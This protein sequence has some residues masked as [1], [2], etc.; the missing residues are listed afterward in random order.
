M[1]FAYSVVFSS[2]SVLKYYAGLTNYYDLGVINESF[3]VATYGG[4]FW[5]VNSVYFAGHFSPILYLF[6]PIYDA[7]PGPPVLLVIQ[8]FVIGFGVLPVYM[9][10][11]GATRDRTVSTMISAVY[12]MYP[13]LQG[14]NAFAFHAASLYP[15]LFGLALL[16]W[17]RRGWSQYYVCLAAI[18]ASHEIAPL[19]IGSLGLANL[20]R[21]CLRLRPSI[22][23]EVIL[24]SILTIAFGVLI[25]LF[26]SA[27]TRIAQSGTTAFYLTGQLRSVS[28]PVA[29]GSWLMTIPGYFLAHPA[30]TVASLFVDFPNKFLYLLEMLGPVMFL[31]VLDLLAL[32]PFWVWIMLIYLTEFRYYYW[33][34]A[35]YSG[36]VVAF[37]FSSLAAVFSKLAMH[38]HATRKLALGMVLITVMMSSYLSPLNPLTGSSGDPLRSNWWFVI[39]PHEEDVSRIIALVPPAASVATELDLAVFVSGRLDL[40]VPRGVNLA[41]A[42]LV[43]LTRLPRKPPDFILADLNSPWFLNSAVPSKSSNYTLYPYMMNL[44]NLARYGVYAYDD[45]VLL[46]KR[47]YYGPPVLFEPYIE[48]FNYNQLSLWTGTG[49]VVEDQSSRSGR[50]LACLNQSAPFFWFGPFV[51]LP[52]GTYDV[53]FDLK[54]TSSF[55]GRVLSLAVV[56]DMGPANVT[57]IISHQIAGSNFSQLSEWENFTFSFHLST[58]TLHVEFLGESPSPNADLYLDYVLVTQ[59][60][61]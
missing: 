8:S 42:S 12:L 35:H 37:V 51:T 49:S 40:W 7:L 54:L 17:E 57:T 53:T 18:G 56:S 32:L 20:I 23:R 38:P 16:F 50:V 30:A 19:L 46:Y 1:A 47:G 55:K 15:L 14:V 27:V 24:H 36:F 4:Q 3:W 33:I 31:P 25:F 10:I 28:L 34:Y 60:S 13:P 41:N 45:N 52:P 9:L 11:H 59:T 44:L 58:P 61:I 39:T 48:T 21:V 29:H 6:L 5:N 26:D 2:F 43:T 22:P